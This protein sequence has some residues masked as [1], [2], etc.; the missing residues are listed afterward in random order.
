[1]LM[2]VRVN[3]ARPPCSYLGQG[4]K[5]P[6]HAGLTDGDCDETLGRDM[7]IEGVCVCVSPSSVHLSALLTCACNVRVILH[8]EILLSCL[9]FPPT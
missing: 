7:D 1:M 3:P 8:G 4:G 2:Q 9:P 5:V 6:G